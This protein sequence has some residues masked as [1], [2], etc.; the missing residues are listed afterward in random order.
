MLL[1]FDEPSFFLSKQMR[2]KNLRSLSISMLPCVCLIFFFLLIW[3]NYIYIRKIMRWMTYGFPLNERKSEKNYNKHT[4]R[5]QPHKWLAN[6]KGSNWFR[7]DKKYLLT[8]NTY[9][10]VYVLLY[11]LLKKY[12]LLIFKRL[13]TNFVELS[14]ELQV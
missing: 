9:V 11:V 13:L 5:K 6:K 14:S 10:D 2:I 12:F 3:M 1:Y 8:L 7:I 4:R